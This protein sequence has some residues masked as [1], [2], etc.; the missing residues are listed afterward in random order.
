MLQMPESTNCAFS[1]VVRIGDFGTFSLATNFDPKFVFSNQSSRFPIQGVFSL[2][3]DLWLSSEMIKNLVWHLMSWNERVSCELILYGPT[4][5]EYHL[6]V[7]CML[8]AKDLFFFI[9]FSWIK[10]SDLSKHCTEASVKPRASRKGLHMIIL[11]TW[12]C[13]FQQQ[14]RSRKKKQKNI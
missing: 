7:S 4:E 10:R 1:N 14:Q 13:F 5:K 6:S 11:V 8:A 3:N 9:S 2:V 12:C